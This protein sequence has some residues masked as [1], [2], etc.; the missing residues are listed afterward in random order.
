MCR[1]A[2]LA[3]S[4]LAG[5][6][7]SQSTPNTEPR[8]TETVRVATS[9]GTRGIRTTPYQD[10]YVGTV[11]FPIASVWAA[12]PA[13]YDSVGLRLTTADAG[14]HTMGNEGVVLRRVLGKTALSKYVDCGK[15]QIDHNADTY[16]VN[17]SLLTR[18]AADGSG[19][20][21]ITTTLAAAAK[22]ISFSGDY[23]RCFSL[24]KLEARLN[25]LLYAELERKA[26]R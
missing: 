25:D 19:A 10:S 2:M 1:V 16:D 18:V 3:L 22:P 15:T 26:A 14:S 7:S 21:K 13:A 9:A 17:L 11:A 5:C 23:V 6:A 8:A 24:G 4:A 12:L 20:T